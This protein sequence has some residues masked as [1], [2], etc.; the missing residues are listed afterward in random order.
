MKT[1]ILNRILHRVIPVVTAFIIFTMSVFCF[2][3]TASAV[4]TAVSYKE[5]ST[6]VAD[7]DNNLVTVSLPSEW[8][9]IRFYDRTDGAFN[10]LS[11]SN[12]GVLTF[13][14]SQSIDAFLITC[15]PFGSW[16]PNNYSLAYDGKY[17]D[18]TEIPSGASYNLS[19]TVSYG[20]YGQVDYPS[21]FT[22]ISAGVEN[23]KST[24][25]KINCNWDFQETADLVNI[26]ANA[27]SVFPSGADGW[28]CH[29]QFGSR[30]YENEPYY[31]G[32]YHVRLLS[33]TVTFTITSLYQLQQETGKTNAILTEVEKQLEANGQKLDEV[34]SSQQ[35]TND[36]LD[37]VI[38]GDSLNDHNVNAPGGFN[39]TVNQQQNQMQNGMADINKVDKPDPN[40]AIPDVGSYVPAEGTNL[41]AV[42]MGGITG[43]SIVPTY[44]LIVVGLFVVSFI[45]FGKKES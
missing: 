37:D 22:F 38:S 11:E 12:N 13:T 6:I 32:T 41:L 15:F 23:G 28:I 25:Q 16:F 7:G 14:N 40:T 26:T 34:I 30:P 31:S 44:L 42:V 27:N 9:L 5:Y 18:L 20:K 29:F 4:G 17:L 21:N 33:S 24:P 39:D 10:L 1:N 3:S 19:F 8:G 36:K 45:M 43:F 35:Q 2:P